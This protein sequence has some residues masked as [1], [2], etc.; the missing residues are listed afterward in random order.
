M[1]ITPKNLGGVLKITLLLLLYFKK[2][3]AQYVYIKI[4]GLK[5]NFKP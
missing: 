5:R 2:T 4:S 1:K 3:T